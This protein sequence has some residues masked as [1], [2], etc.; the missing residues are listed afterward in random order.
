MELDELLSFVD[1]LQSFQQR[2]ESLAARIDAQ[3]ASLHESW[4]GSAADEHRARHNEWMAASADMR[5]AAVELRAAAH[6]AHQNYTTAA[7][8]NLAML[9]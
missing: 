4:S 8:L 3:V 5:E 2:A 7:Q 1:R 6:N 9:T